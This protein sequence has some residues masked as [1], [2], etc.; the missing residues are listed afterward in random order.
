MFR[1]GLSILLVGIVVNGSNIFAESLPQ[2]RFKSF[3]ESVMTDSEDA[4]LNPGRARYL[5]L[6]AGSLLKRK[7]IASEESVDGLSRSCEVVLDKSTKKVVAAVFLAAQ[8]VSDGV[9][10]AYCFRLDPTGAL[11][12][13][14][15]THGL[16][17]DGQAVKGSGKAEEVDV[18]APGIRAKLQHELDF[19]LKGKYR[20]KAGKPS[21]APAAAQ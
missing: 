21:A 4:V 19:W 14:A 8:P 7:D 3:I 12:T 16:M 13:V 11:K 20:K 18:N 15:L 5:G 17:K 9:R 10:E 1:G 2:K 6:Q